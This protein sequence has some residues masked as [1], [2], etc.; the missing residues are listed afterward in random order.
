VKPPRPP[1]LARWLVALAL[2]GEIGEIVRGDLDQ[3]FHESVTD[4]AA[5]RAVRRRYWRQ[6]IAS[7]SAVRT[8]RADASH[9]F[10]IHHTG[11]AS[12][13][14]FAFSTAF[15]GIRADLRHVGRRLAASPGFSLV[16]ILSLAIGIGANTAIASVARAALFEPMPVERPDE[17]SFIFWTRQEG[18][19][20]MY[21]DGSLDPRTGDRTTSNVTY[22]ALVDLR[23]SAGGAVGAFTFIPKSNVVIGG[24]PAESAGGLLVD[25]NFFSVLRPPMA[26]G[27]GLTESD[28]RPGA[29]PVVVI[30]YDFW[31]HAAAGS[32]SVLDLPI[33]VNGVPARIVGVTA[34]GF[35]GLSPGGF[36]PT[37]DISMPMSMQP[38]AV[39]AWTPKQGSLFTEPRL[40]WVRAI[41]RI[42]ATTS[43]DEF[44]TMATS[45]LRAHVVDAGITDAAAAGKVHASLMPAG[46]G[47]DVSDAA[48]KTS[49]TVLGIVVT[50]VLLITCL[51]LAGL[52]L[53]RSVAR[54]REL[55]VRTALGASRW[56]LVR[57]GLL[58]SAVLAA[59]G[60]ALGLALTFA[61]RSMLAAALIDGLGPVTGSVTIDMPLFALTLAV[62]TAAALIAGLVPSLQL[63]SRAMTSGSQ[64]RPGGTTAPR[65]IAG[66]VLLAIQI[67]GSVP[68]VAGAGLLLRTM[69][70][71]THVDV[72]FDASTVLTFRVEAPA[73]PNGDAPIA[74]YT[75]ILSQLREVPGVRTASL[76]ENSLISGVS[77]SRSLLIDGQKKSVYTNAIASGFFD[78]LAA[79]L[80]AGRALDD[81]DAAGPEHVVVNKTLADRFG[82]GLGHHFLIPGSEP[83]D[84]DR[85]VEVVGIAADM[86]Y[87]S[88]RAATPPTIFDHF[89][90]H[91][92][93]L[94]GV[95]F[96]VRTDR[97][98]A[99]LER[100]IRD[101]VAAVTPNIAATAFRTQAAQ[102]DRTMGRERVFARLLA[103]FAAFA[104][105]LACI[106]LHGVTSYSVERRTNEIGVRIALG[107]QRGQ[108]LWLVFRNVLVLGA[109]G[110]VIGIPAAL[111][112]APLLKTLVF[113][114]AASD[115]WTLAA[116][117]TVMLGIT[118][119]AG[120]IPARRAA[121]L[122]PLTAIRR[123]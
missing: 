71:L 16:A 81:R 5:M 91:R 37:T 31:Q 21:S 11:A 14:T 60:G 99:Q 66:R 55:A 33:S 63:S 46:R 77:S 26:L 104:L 107:A 118:I 52:M 110:L 88:L 40:Q 114:L 117:A 76:V 42:P 123:D 68:L 79:P 36:R 56:R 6:A 121:S 83:G 62:T 25:G 95:T 28:D 50:V 112:A 12:M 17:L 111:A 61:G 49:V 92:A 13:P 93:W 98:P 108:V 65:Q 72:G 86:K 84:A 96:M 18:L 89:A 15:T 105:L 10:A 113:G 9:T 94:S 116:A 8:A 53:A 58:E 90:R 39:A 41:A 22:P 57:L 32:T 70:N 85:D 51:N 87:T 3:E 69:N 59:A 64:Q 23:K 54:Q 82:A 27:R 109:V 30:G 47:I 106:G 2:R 38:R 44:E 67:A 75:R 34:R 1:L 115:P 74:A 100:P 24:Q 20:G 4:G 102:I 120:W 48:T 29:E 73:A 45:T 101:A 43:R 7:V 80:I 19:S 78:T 97:N 122:D 35:R 103:V 119:V